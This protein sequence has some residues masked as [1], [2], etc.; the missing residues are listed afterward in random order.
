[1]GLAYGIR[2]Y[3]Q[4]PSDQP[5]SGLSLPTAT[6]LGFMSVGILFSKPQEGMIRLV[7]QR[8]P[9]G[10]LIK[11]FGFALL[12]AF[13]VFGGLSFLNRREMLGQSTGLL[14]IVSAALAAWFVAVA[15]SCVRALEV[16]ERERGRAQ[17][18]LQQSETLLQVVI[19]SLP[20]GVWILRPDGSARS[21]NPA[22]QKIWDN[23]AGDLLTL[24][25]CDAWCELS[26]KKLELEHW[27]AYRALYRGHTV[28][29]EL[30]RIR[31]TEKSERYIL[32]SAIPLRDPSGLING[33]VMVHE[34]ITEQ[35][36]AE[37]SAKEAEARSKVLLERANDAIRVREDVLSIVSHD[38]KNPLT[39]ANLAVQLMR[40][41]L[42][43]L[44]E[45]SALDR[46]ASSI[47]KSINSMRTLVQSILDIGKIQS[48][49]FSVE[50]E[51]LAVTTIFQS[52]DEVMQTIAR[53]KGVEL[54]V[55]IPAIP[56]PVLADQS[57]IM[58][59][60]MNLVANAVK[61]TA[62][63]GKILV[64]CQSQGGQQLFSVRDTGKGIPP[65]QLR[66]IFERNWQAPGTAAAGNGLG[67]FI[68]KG[69]V[70]AHGGQ[71][72]VESEVGRGSNFHFTIPAA[73]VPLEGVLE[74][75]S[76]Q[77]VKTADADLGGGSVYVA[78]SV[79]VPP[80][81]IQPDL[82]GNI[83]LNPQTGHPG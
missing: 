77:G 71:I 59:V 69:I 73:P 17:N 45:S 68:A 3:Y 51:P 5:L 56:R 60:L 58:Q 33:A 35:R 20:V 4:L 12:I 76:G 31:P 74:G 83:E 80:L 47:Q 22:S 46:T 30:I 11:R 70:E 24:A 8:S 29:G 82:F 72:W 18:E 66:K 63:G 64:S 62:G 34:E 39:A 16:M 48:G 36:R 52:L 40:R 61:F 78:K 26:G 32:S 49:T 41:H 6:A 43:K 65:T 13:S 54:C 19:Q 79:T 1:M 67:L 21:V 75:Q 42:K 55:E 53:E 44:P 57:R 7:L 14:S 27:A 2:Y 10:E 37:I 23:Q 15:W 28:I 81:Q 25:R 38:L 9:G 50:P